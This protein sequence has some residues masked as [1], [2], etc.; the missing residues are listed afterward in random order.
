M[1][2]EKLLNLR[3]LVKLYCQSNLL[4][5]SGYLTGASRALIALAVAT[6]AG[7]TTTCLRFCVFIIDNYQNFLL[8]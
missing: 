6:I 1:N 4:S 8:I 3:A 5:I 7:P 2:D